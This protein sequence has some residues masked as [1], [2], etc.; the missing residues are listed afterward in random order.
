[1]K[2]MDERYNEVRALLGVPKNSY[3]PDFHRMSSM[4]M[5]FWNC[6]GASNN[7]FKRTLKELVRTHK[8]KIL[9][10]M[11][12]KVEL[13]S[14]VMFFNRLG[15]TAS[16][17]FDPVGRSGGIWMLWNPSQANVRVLEANSQII[18]ATI[19]RQNDPNWLLSAVYA[20]PNA[21]KREEMW[22]TLE[23]IA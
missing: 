20:S 3:L 18:T 9:V 2:S 15:F 23:Q 21:R 14:M 11:E 12:T 6:R 13:N 17:H 22:Q 7:T 4:D 5:L 10:L 19:S 1:M 8:P 16:T